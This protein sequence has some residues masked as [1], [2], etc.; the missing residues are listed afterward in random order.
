MFA[1]LDVEPAAADAFQ[2]DLLA[3]V[4]G[5]DR[6][7]LAVLGC[8]LVATERALDFLALAVDL[9][10]AHGAVRQRRPF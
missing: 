7:L 4:L 6:Q 8:G 10:I 1:L 9:A 2:I 5:A 3:C